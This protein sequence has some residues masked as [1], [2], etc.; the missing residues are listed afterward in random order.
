MDYIFERLSH[1]FAFALLYSQVISSLYKKILSKLN[2]KQDL[3]IQILLLLK[4]TPATLSSDGT[5]MVLL[6]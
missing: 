5:A 1:L 6:V 4:F 2:E 3:E